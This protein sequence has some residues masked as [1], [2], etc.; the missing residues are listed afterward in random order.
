[1]LNSATIDEAKDRIS[2]SIRLMSQFIDDFE[3]Q[4]SRQGA[5][6]K[7]VTEVYISINNQI[8][9]FLPKKINIILP[10]TAKLSELKE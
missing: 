9:N 8:S 10:E 3:G 1:M 7:N 5:K 4:R 2:R 6:K